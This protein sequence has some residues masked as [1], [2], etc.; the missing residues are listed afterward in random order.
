MA[1]GTPVMAILTDSAERGE[2]NIN[3]RLIGITAI[4][5]GGAYLFKNFVTKPD[6]QNKIADTDG[7]GAVLPGKGL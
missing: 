3:W 5:G 1:V 4:A 6:A 7:D 2:W